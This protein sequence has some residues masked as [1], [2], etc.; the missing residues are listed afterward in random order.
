MPLY[1]PDDSQAV[2]GVALAMGCYRTAL[3]YLLLLGRDSFR[4][5][6][7]L[8]FV[9][10]LHGFCVAFLAVF[11]FHADRHLL[12]EIVCQKKGPII[13]PRENPGAVFLETGFLIHKRGCGRI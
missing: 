3:V 8:F 13:Q 9:H 2:D 12:M 7:L 6:F 4:F 5:L 1:L 10:I 11:F